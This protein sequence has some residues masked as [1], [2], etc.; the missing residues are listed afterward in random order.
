MSEKNIEV[1]VLCFVLVVLIFL[2]FALLILYR[3]LG[4]KHMHKDP[5]QLY[6]YTYTCSKLKIIP[7][8]YKTNCSIKIAFTTSE[9]TTIK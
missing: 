2:S 5:E 4:Y 7:N 3:R 9:V 8:Y 6:A 1:N